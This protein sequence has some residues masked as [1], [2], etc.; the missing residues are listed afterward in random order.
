M[1]HLLTL[2]Y[3]LTA[4]VAFSFTDTTLVQVTTEQNTSCETAY[5]LC[6]NVYQNYNTQNPKDNDLPCQKPTFFY[7]FEMSSAS[8][9]NIKLLQNGGNYVLY[10]P[11][12]S[13]IFLNCEAIYQYA[14]NS[15]NGTLSTGVNTNINVASGFY[16][17][18]VNC[19]SCI[20]QI[21][22]RMNGKFLS[23][24]SG[25]SCADCVSSFSPM[26]G[27]YVVSAWVKENN[28]PQATKNYTKPYLRISFAGTSNTFN[29]TPSGKIIDGWQKIDSIIS[30]PSN[31]TSISIALK[32]TSGDAYFDDIRFFPIDGSMMSY[33]Y[34]PINLRLMAELD[35]RNFATLYEYDEEGK[36]IRIKKETERGVM[37]IQENRDNI[38]KH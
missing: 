18:Q 31:A 11:F 21:Q 13:D 26:P 12:N 28:A 37:T 36:L 32:V 7:R 27:K 29:L 9:F 14:A 34:D 5:K 17:L 4:Y 35:E 19:S 20:G 38:L 10:G 16:V 8:S 33:V 15:L 22:L 3:L 2:I 23:C 24:T 30:I 6:R 1:K 25:T